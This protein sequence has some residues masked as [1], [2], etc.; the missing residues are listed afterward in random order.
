ME[1][2]RDGHNCREKQAGYSEEIR[3]G[4]ATQTWILIPRALT[5]AV[6]THMG[7]MRSAEVT[8]ADIK[9]LGRLNARCR[10]KELPCKIPNLNTIRNPDSF[11]HP[12]QQ[13]KS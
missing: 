13:C 3:E 10:K 2:L 1:V 6:N 7:Y 8:W 12:E 9:E 4:I 11:P 5:W